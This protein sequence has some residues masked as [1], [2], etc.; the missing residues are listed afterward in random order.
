MFGVESG[1]EEGCRGALA[2]AR[3][4]SQRMVELNTSLRGEIDQPLRIGIGI[5][6]GPVIVG[7]MGYGG[8]SS[9]TAI[10]DAVNTAS[11][12][13]EL[14]KEY[15]CELVVSEAVVARAGVDLSAFPGH[16]IEI[17]GKREKLAV[18]TLPSPP[19]SPPQVRP[20]HSSRRPAHSGARGLCRIL[21]APPGLLVAYRASFAAQESQTGSFVANWWYKLD[22]W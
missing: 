13:E 2:A 21:E 10:G 22:V 19:N 4:M 18:R 6:A 20:V 14:T 8:A 17:R 7:E 16:E 1:A 11:R 12:L 3:L 5:H 9:I 15:G